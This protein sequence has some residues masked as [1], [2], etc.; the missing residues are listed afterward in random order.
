MAVQRIARKRIEIHKTDFES[1]GRGFES[2]RARHFTILH[3][4]VRFCCQST[5]PT[6]SISSRIA[7][8]QNGQVSRD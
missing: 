2:L 4:A 1:G 8:V 5:L 7:R 6:P 3:D